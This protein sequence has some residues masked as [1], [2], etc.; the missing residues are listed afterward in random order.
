[1][2]YIFVCTIEVRD[3]DMYTTRWG[4]F[5]FDFTSVELLAIYVFCALDRLPLPKSALRGSL[6]KQEG[7]MT[8]CVVNRIDETMYICYF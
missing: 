3:T 8:D 6:L 7:A 2:H 1:V 5:Y 4:N